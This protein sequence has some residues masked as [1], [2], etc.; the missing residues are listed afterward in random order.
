[1]DNRDW[2]SVAEFGDRLSARITSTR[3]S[4]ANVPNRVWQ[5]PRSA[6]QCFIWVPADREDEAKRILSEVPVTER[7]LTELALA[8]AP[9]DDVG[10]NAAGQNEGSGCLG[11]AIVAA[12]VILFITPVGLV[13]IGALARISSSCVSTPLW[14]VP[15][16]D[17]LLKV[18]V[19]RQQ[20][21]GVNRGGGVSI[22]SGTRFI[23]RMSGANL[24]AN[25]AHPEALSIRWEGRRNVVI[26]YKLDEALK[27]PRPWFMS[28][29]GPVNVRLEPK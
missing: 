12:V 22:L 25:V 11:K 4:N 6:G 20:C 3:L 5:P 29:Y 2:V 8:E 7:E 13:A 14:E 17:A 27:L 10:S 18:S 24:L 28:E 1:M 16:P 9:P 26:G 15:S 19:F 21:H 23:G